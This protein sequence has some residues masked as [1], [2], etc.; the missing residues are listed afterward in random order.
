[1]QEILLYLL[2][3]IGLSGFFSGAEVALVSVSK[4]KSK[5]LLEQKVKR[6]K[7]LFYLKENFQKTLIA[8]LI[9]NNLVNIAGSAIA[10]KIAL[11][12]FGDA[13][14]GIATGVMTFLILTFGEIIPKTFCSKHSLRISLII[15][16]IIY[17]LMIILSPIIWGFHKFSVFANKF[18]PKTPAEY[19]VTE[20]ELRYMIRIGEEQGQIKPD[21]KEMIQNIL[22]FDDTIINEVMTPRT[23]I[24]ALEQEQTIQEVLPQIIKEGYSRIPI[25]EKQLDKIK[26]ILVVS[27]ILDVLSKKKPKTKLKKL[28][29]K[30]IFVPENKKTDILLRELQQ[31][32]SHMAIVVNEHGSVEGVVTIEDLLE[33]IVGDI[34][35]ESDEIEQLVRPQGRNQWLV[36]GKTPIRYLNKK[37]KLGLSNN[38]NF[39]TI[40]GFLQHSLNKVPTNGDVF[41]LDDKN[42]RFTVKKVEGPQILEI[43]ITKE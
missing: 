36:L 24:F 39:N 43:I 38:D 35:D 30:A 16:P 1:M 10:T 18:G 32:S 9:G 26:G 22:R 41:D 14:V 7:Y 28:V 19:V 34:Y 11:D 29:R 8:I 25:Y 40:S 15:S 23:Q 31:K 27:D 5:Q 21:E 33:E 13:G 17:F 3:T 6:A 20:Q 37:L 4:L 12:A 2:I 42:I